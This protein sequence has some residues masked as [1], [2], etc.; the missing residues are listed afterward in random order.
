MQG[1][2]VVV[3]KWATWC[4]PCRKTIPHLNKVY[5]QYKD[6]ESFQLVAITDET[7]VEKIKSFMKQHKMQYPVAS[8]T[9]GK[10]TESY[11]A[12]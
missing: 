12:R 6:Q 2:V 7:D 1:K 4:P 11:N 3:E 9:D 10:A 8:D 5:Q